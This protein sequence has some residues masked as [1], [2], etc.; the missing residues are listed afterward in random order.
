[1]KKIKI[2]RRI[3][4]VISQEEYI[5]RENDLRDYVW[6]IEYNLKKGMQQGL[7][8]GRE[9]GLEQG[10]EQGRELG[11]E[12]GLE[13]GRSE[14]IAIGEKLGREKLIRNFL[15]AISEKPWVTLDDIADMEEILMK[16]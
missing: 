7:E 8:Q 12:Q 16:S 10:L 9:L 2:G 5:R 11:L 15:D 3:L 14:G 6:E 4:E 13:Q 1:M